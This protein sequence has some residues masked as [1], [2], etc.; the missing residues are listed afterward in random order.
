[1]LRYPDVM[2][3]KREFEESI[4]H[5]EWYT[6]SANAVPIFVNFTAWCAFTMRDILGYGYERFWWRFC[7]GYTDMNYWVRDLQRLWKI[8][9]ENLNRDPLYLEKIKHMWT[10]GLRSNQEFFDRLDAVSLDDM[11]DEELVPVMKDCAR[12]QVRANG[13]A[14]IIEP[15]GQEGEKEL[16]K[17][18]AADLGEKSSGSHFV[19][20]TAPSELSFVAREERALWKISFLSKKERDAA[21]MRHIEKYFWV[22]NTYR[23]SRPLTTGILRERLD[24]FRERKS[25]DVTAQVSA[26]KE[27]V[28]T[29]PLS[30]KT[31]QLI[32]VI[33]FTAVW[34]DQRKEHILRSISYFA[35]VL[36]EVARRTKLT[37]DA[38]YQLS[39]SDLPAIESLERITDLTGELAERDNGVFFYWEGA[40]ESAISGQAYRQLEKELTST[41]SVHEGDQ[42][43][44]SIANTGTAT[45]RVSVCMNLSSLHKV[46]KGDILVTSMTRPEFMPALRRAAALVTDE[47]GITSHAAIVS[48]ELGIPAI[49]G[50]KIGTKVLKDGM[51][52]E[53]RAHHGFVRIL[54][55]K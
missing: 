40:D 25:D 47:G 34:Q 30:E 6:Q 23:G 17:R 42:I 3:W 27:L 39:V 45:G 14:H 37:T 46:Q 5:E 4:K 50:T 20:L 8:I 11:T 41:G 26:K 52:V 28:D 29:L 48:R 18:L 43:Y 12:A 10:E 2:T 15:I 33:D 16:K 9:D 44:G 21:L 35:R 51:E 53:V 19:L 13:V 49:I 36:D 55:K 31:K 24:T 54:R 7:K 1:M 22:Q 32:E 38:L